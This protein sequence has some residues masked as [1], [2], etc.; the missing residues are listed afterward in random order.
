MENMDDHVLVIDDDPLAERIAVHGER[1]DPVV[2]FQPFL[3]LSRDGF[4][5]R[6]RRAGADDEKIG[7]RGNAAQVQAGD[8]FG[9][10]AR[11]EFRA[12]QCER[13]GVNEKAPCTDR[14][15]K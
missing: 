1:A 10:L 11:G 2:F 13:F 8:V 12:E 3:D 14:V 7:E 4:Q 5:V 6:L 9:F 15:R